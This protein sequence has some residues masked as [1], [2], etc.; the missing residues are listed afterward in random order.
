MLEQTLAQC[1]ADRGVLVQ[2]GSPAAAGW[3]TALVVRVLCMALPHAAHAVTGIAD[4]VAAWRP[5]AARLLV[6]LNAALRCILV[7]EEHLADVAGSSAAIAA[8]TE[9]CPRERALRESQLLLAAAAAPV[10]GPEQQLLFSLLATCAKAVRTRVFWVL[11][12]GGLEW[13]CGDG[14]AHGGGAACQRGRH[15]CRAWQGA[16]GGACGAAVHDL[17]AVLSLAVLDEQLLHDDV[18]WYV[19]ECHLGC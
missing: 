7:D 17:G 13:L 18:S 10:H 4:V 11:A 16:L 12:C 2:A 5:V 1:G 14:T 9:S 3:D 6:S 15:A 8:A 19:Q